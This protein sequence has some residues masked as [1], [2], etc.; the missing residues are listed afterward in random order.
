MV[1][2]C[3]KEQSQWV[4]KQHF[5]VTPLGVSW[6]WLLPVWVLKRKATKKQTNKTVC[7][8]T[9][10]PRLLPSSHSTTEEGEGECVYSVSSW[11]LYHLCRYVVRYRPTHGCGSGGCLGVAACFGAGW[12][13]RVSSECRKLQLVPTARIS[14]SQIW[15]E[16]EEKSHFKEIV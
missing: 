15:K 11:Q 8:T 3:W 7:Q 1:S 13:T 5:P 6:P 14:L 4:R 16:E 2:K 9:D 12:T 10:K